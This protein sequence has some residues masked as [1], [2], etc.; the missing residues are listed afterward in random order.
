MAYVKD[1]AEKDWLGRERH[2]TYFARRR[3][4][5]KFASELKAKGKM[6]VYSKT[7]VEGHR[8]RALVTWIIDEDD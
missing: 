5:R 7:Y 6:I 3:D 4:A 8:C 2:V 1:Y